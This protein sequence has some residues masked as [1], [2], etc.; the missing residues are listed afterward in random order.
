MEWK[1]HGT[2]NR[3]AE[4]AAR[5]A[6][7]LCKVADFRPRHR[8]GGRGGQHR[9]FLRPHRRYNPAGG[10]SLADLA[11]P[12]WR[13]SHRGAVPVMRHGA[14]QGH[15]LR[16]GGRTGER[17]PPV[18]HRPPGLSLHRPH[19][20]GG[21]IVGPGGGHSADRRLHLLQNRPLDAP[22][23]QG[24]P[25][26]HHVRHVGGLCRSV[27]HPAD[28]GHVC[29]GGRQRRGALLCRHRPLRSLRHH[30]ALG[31]QGLWRTR[32]CL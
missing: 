12:C 28:G 7:D 30:R 23:R 11:S 20:S 3:T 26:Y 24:Q 29:H 31:I 32:H 13:R 16:A 9:L 27:R 21:R 22:G 10:Q 18:A 1:R 8:A 25:G 2:E 5:S 15:Q 4:E 6:W 19:P 17:R 14:G